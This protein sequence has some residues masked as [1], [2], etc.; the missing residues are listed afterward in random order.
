MNRIE[1]NLLHQI[2]TDSDFAYYI[3]ERIDI[4]DFDNP[5]ANKIYDR[6]VQLLFEEKQITFEGLIE[7]FAADRE[8]VKGIMRCER[9]Q[10]HLAPSGCSISSI[11]C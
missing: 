1:A 6:I 5:I 8:V 11:V 3:T 2:I 10:T 4:G 7:D 9:T